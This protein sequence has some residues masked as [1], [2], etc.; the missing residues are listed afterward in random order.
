MAKETKEKVKKPIYKRWWFWVI[1]VL[2][3]FGAF[4]GGGKSN[5][6]ATTTDTTET[7][8]ETATE[9]TS[10]DAIVLKEGE[11]GE[12]GTAEKLEQD[13]EVLKEYIAYRVPSGTYTITNKGA[14]R[15]QITVYKDGTNVNEDGNVEQNMSD[16][17]PL[18]L[19]ANASDTLTI[20]DGEYI[21]IYE[22]DVIELVAQ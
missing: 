18:L 1:I 22:N 16:T 15:T 5:E 21:E 11:L 14:N 20:N 12:Y 4:S 3:V 7:T 8:T 17:K 19:D 2:L 13:G 6:E 10:A 9:Q